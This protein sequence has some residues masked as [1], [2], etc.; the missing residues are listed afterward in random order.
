MNLQ[1]NTLIKEK[2]IT[3]RQNKKQFMPRVVLKRSHESETILL[4]ACF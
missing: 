2:K 1:N 4:V 3:F